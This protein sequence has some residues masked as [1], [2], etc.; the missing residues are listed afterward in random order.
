[1]ADQK[2]T[3]SINR[4]EVPDQWIDTTRRKLLVWAVAASVLWITGIETDALAQEVKVAQAWT[5][6][7]IKTA[8]LGGSTFDEVMAKDGGYAGI[9]KEFLWTSDPQIIAFIKREGDKYIAS[10]PQ[11]QRKKWIE[12]L[13]AELSSLLSKAKWSRPH[14]HNPIQSQ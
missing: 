2:N 14:G 7:A 8:S 9:V 3:S 6:N 11:D 10:L 13:D 12:K 1:M 4:N 5:T